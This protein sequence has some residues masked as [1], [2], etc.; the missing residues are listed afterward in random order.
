MHGRR[1]WLGVKQIKY[2]SSSVVIESRIFKSPETGFDPL[3]GEGEQDFFCLYESTL[4][5]TCLCLIPIR[6][7]AGTATKFGHMLKIR[8][9]SVVKE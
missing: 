5:Q 1:G 9:P 7:Y 6:V 3:A 4:V 8:Y 2:L